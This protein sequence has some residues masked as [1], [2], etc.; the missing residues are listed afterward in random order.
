M[1][2]QACYE[3]ALENHPQRRNIEL[4]AEAGRLR[5]QIIEAE[6]KPDFNLAARATLQSETVSLPFDIPNQPGIEL[7]LF[8]MRASVEGSYTIYDG[9]LNEA[10]REVEEAVLRTEQQAVRV[11]L[12]KLKP[13]V[14]EHFFSLLLIRE[15]IEIIEGSI[16]VLQQKERALRGGV[17][18]GAVLPRQA[19]QL[20]V[21]I[22]RMQSSREELV[23]QLDAH[24]GSLG[25]LLGRQVDA[26]VELEL[27][28]LELP[29]DLEIDNR[30]AEIQQFD[31]QMRQI[32]SQKQLWQARRRPR[33]SS[34]LEAG[35]GYPNPLNFF[36]DVLSPFAMGGLSLRWAITDWK[37]KEREM[38]ILD[39]R[40]QIVKEHEASFRQRVSQKDEQ[41]MASIRGARRQYRYDEDILK[42]QQQILQSTAGEFERGVITASEYLEQVHAEIRA[43]I[44][45]YAGM[46]QLIRLK[47]EYLT[48]KGW[49]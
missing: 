27:P 32:L 6:S 35:V 13:V 49:M 4:L 18:E 1:S 15:K 34:F 3:L 30:Q 16:R 46:L 5:S 41:F 21:E 23:R 42:L 22:L 9:G 12:E 10:R 43:R 26:A 37:Q 25:V 40:A 29:A 33:V 31:D 24:A 39:L 17:R 47:V 48:H 8:Q 38:E 2:L 45:R 19:D 44:D 14:N 36:E 20:K 7:P 11:E 28:E